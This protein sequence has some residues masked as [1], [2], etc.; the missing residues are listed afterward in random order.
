MVLTIEGKAAEAI[1]GDEIVL[2]RGEDGRVEKPAELSGSIRWEVKIP[3]PD[4][5]YVRNAGSS[6]IKRELLEGETDGTR[7][8]G[9]ADGSH[10]ASVK[11][12]S[13]EDALLTANEKGNVTVLATDEN[14]KQKKVERNS[15]I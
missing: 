2:V 12:L 13:G 4:G 7:K 1:T 3:K 8:A 10:I 14:G 6:K 9:D 15:S 11:K 5:N